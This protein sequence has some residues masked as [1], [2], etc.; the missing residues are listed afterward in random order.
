MRYKIIVLFLIT[1]LF[2]ACSKNEEQKL[3]NMN[4]PA[5]ANQHKVVVQEIVQVSEYSYLQVVEGDKEYWIACPKAEFS[6]GQ[7][8]LYNQAMEMK[9]F[10]SKELNRTFESIFFVDKLETKLGVG[11]MTQ[12]Q[13]PVIEKENIS[14]EPVSGGI[15]IAQLF[16][17]PNSYANKTVKIK[18]KVVKVNS[19]IMNKNWIHIQDGTSASGEF[20]LTVTT[21]D[22]ANVGE[23]LILEGKIVLNKD[24]GYG[25]SYKV[26][27]EEARV[28][29]SL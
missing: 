16:S 14:L 27:M 11:S 26:L 10:T 13:K 4:T 15:T 12:P 29:K 23:V 24:F 1:I 5:K 9:D 21:N 28:S 3:Q 8:L 6:K 19:G 18:G 17:N 20:D 25:Y 22:F 2:S 7:V